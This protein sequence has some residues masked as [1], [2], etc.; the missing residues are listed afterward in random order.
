MLILVPQLLEGGDLEEVIAEHRRKKRYIKEEAIWLYF[1]QIA[2]GIQ[3]CHVPEIR[4]G[5]EPDPRVI[6]HRDLKEANREC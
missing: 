1:S 6:L 5:S 4:V 3:Q 2:Q